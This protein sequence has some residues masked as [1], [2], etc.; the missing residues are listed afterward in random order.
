MLE[1]VF[2]QAIIFYL[3]ILTTNMEH[4]KTQRIFFTCMHFAIKF[5]VFYQY[6]IKL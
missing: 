2:E 1:E 6:M 4:D 3:F 5:S